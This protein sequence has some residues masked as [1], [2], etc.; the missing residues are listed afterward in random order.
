MKKIKHLVFPILLHF[1]N[2][3]ATALERCDKLFC[4]MP[5][6]KTRGKGENNKLETATTSLKVKRPHLKFAMVEIISFFSLDLRFTID[7]GRI[8]FMVHA[9]HCFVFSD[10]FRHFQ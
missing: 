8:S 4:C 5:N 6:D 1:A 10:L 9:R 7:Y 2:I 3:D